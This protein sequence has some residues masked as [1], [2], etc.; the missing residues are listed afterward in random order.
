MGTGKLNDPDLE[1]AMEL[2]RDVPGDFAE[3]G[4]YKANLFKR[5]CHEAEK[6]G[7]RA[8][9][10]DSF[11]GMDNPTPEIDGTH[12][13]RGAMSVGGIGAFK[14]ILADD[15]VNPEVYELHPGYVPECFGD[16][17]HAYAFIY[18]DL[19]HY[20]PTWTALK[21]ACNNLAEGGLIG[22]DDHFPNRDILAGKAINEFLKEHLTW[23]QFVTDNS[24]I[25]IRI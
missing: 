21:W 14:K 1:R 19:D 18:L 9:A 13:P 6:Q 25:F 3:V 10:Y 12:Y 15:G 17:N 4:V 2:V 24:Q 8:I 5:L 20:K 11:C 7:R 23:T 16:E 22:M